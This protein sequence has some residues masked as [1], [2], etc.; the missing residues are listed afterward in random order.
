MIVEIT[1]L[2]AAS[3]GNLA[4]DVTGRRLNARSRRKQRRARRPLALPMLVTDEGDDD[5]FRQLAHVAP[6]EFLELTLRTV[7][8]LDR[9]VDHFDLVL[10][11]AEAGESLVGDIVY[12][13]ARAPRERGKELL[14]AWLAAVEQ[15]PAGVVEQLRE[16]GLPDQTLRELLQAERERGLWPHADTASDLLEKTANELERA[17][18]VLIGF[19][20]ALR[21]ITRDPYR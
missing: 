8:E 13:G 12:V 6:P 17:V 20:R 11:R 2:I 15:L 16:V 14:D 19:F 1:L 9:V 7:E 5:P 3:V 4:W 10:L 18:L 21:E